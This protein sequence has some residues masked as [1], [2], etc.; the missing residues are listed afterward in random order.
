MA[1]T[2]PGPAEGLTFSPD[3][4]TLVAI[5]ADRVTLWDIPSQVVHATL[6]PLKSEAGSS[7][8]GR[9]ANGFSPDGKLFAMFENMHMQLWNTV[10][11]ELVGLTN[12]RETTALRG[13]WMGR[14]GTPFGE[15]CGQTPEQCRDA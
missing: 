4:Q 6:G 10:T 5:Y 2:L 15:A 7:Y 11:G 14:P 8:G 1:V 3:G 13:R 12:S 9:R